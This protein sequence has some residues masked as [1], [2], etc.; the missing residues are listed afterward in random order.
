METT[1][2]TKDQTVQ[3]LH[4]NMKYMST[5]EDRKPWLSPKPDKVVEV[6]KSNLRSDEVPEDKES[7]ANKQVS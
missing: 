1:S 2:T 3:M 7:N 4:L 6:N 5:I